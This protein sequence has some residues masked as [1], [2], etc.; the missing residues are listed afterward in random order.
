MMKW[1]IKERQNPQLGTYFVPMGQLS[2]TR[3]MAHEDTLY[4]TNV[5]HSFDTEGQYRQRL[6]QLKEEGAKINA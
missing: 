6:A 5:M 4:G 1:W 3:A 2:K